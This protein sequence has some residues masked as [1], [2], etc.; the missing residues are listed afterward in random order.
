MKT[1][2]WPLLVLIGLLCLVL[3]GCR[4]AG[5]Q[6]VLENEIY[7]APQAAYSIPLYI[8]PFRGAVDAGERCNATGGSTTFWDEHGR[9][10]RID[11]LKI[12]E[13]RMAQA[14]RFASDQTLLNAVMNNYLREILPSAESVADSDTSVREF[15]KDRE[16]RALF[17]IVNMNVD[18]N[19]VAGGQD[20]T[21]RGTYYYGFLLFRRG[22]YVYVLQHYQPALMRDKMLQVLNRLAD[23]MIIPGK[24]RSEADNTKDR[25]I[26]R[27][28][29]SG[30]A[31]SEKP[32]QSPGTSNPAASG[33]GSPAPCD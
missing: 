2:N 29:G 10:F 12:D 27:P 15:L 33:K 9:F 8:N 25:T 23:A 16:P 3:G 14:P 1:A 22:E 6:G 4:N 30:D 21:I 19:R 5:M 13:N 28:S 20:T 17:T 32:F 31:L 18:T 24:P 26:W 7:H 11:Y